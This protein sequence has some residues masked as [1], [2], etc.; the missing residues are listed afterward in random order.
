MSCVIY[1]PVFVGIAP[2]MANLWEGQ[3]FLRKGGPVLTHSLDINILYFYMLYYINNDSLV[4]SSFPSLWP[5]KDYTTLL[6]TRQICTAISTRAR[7]RLRVVRRST[8]CCRPQNKSPLCKSCHLFFGKTHAETRMHRQSRNWA[9]PSYAD[10]SNAICW[11]GLRIILTL[12][13]DRCRGLFFTKLISWKR[14]NIPMSDGCIKSS[15][16][17]TMILFI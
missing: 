16:I 3:E 1:T 15:T 10:S 17:P 7:D 12:S 2:K 6:C 5:N 8:S 13:V 14:W 9:N 4:S 11:Q